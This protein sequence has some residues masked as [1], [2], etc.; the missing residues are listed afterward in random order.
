MSRMRFKG[1]TPTD[2]ARLLKEAELE[3]RKSAFDVM[4]EETTKVKEISQA[5]APYDDGQLE[6]AHR[7]IIRRNQSNKAS[8][9]IEVGGTVNGVNVDEYAEIIHEGIGWTK[10][11]KESDAKQARVSPLIVGDHFLS[12]AFDDRKDLI[13][14]R[15]EEAVRRGV[16]RHVG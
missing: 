15:V 10:L 5:Q 7:I 3:G 11:G 14:K 4:R 8:Y 13:I 1:L 9:I 12:R 2:L 16:T 6:A